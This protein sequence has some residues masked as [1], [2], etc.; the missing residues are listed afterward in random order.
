MIRLLARPHSTRHG[1]FEAWLDGE[2]LCISATPLVSAARVLSQ[3]GAAD[4]TILVLRHFG[5]DFDALGTTVGTA[6]QIA[7]VEGDRR[8]LFLQRWRPFPSRE[9]AE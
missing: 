5:S 2:C 1:D 3:R 4:D 8:G 7:V 6:A 9:A